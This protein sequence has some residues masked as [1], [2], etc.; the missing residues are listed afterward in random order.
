MIPQK[1]NFFNNILF[2][3]QNML[4]AVEIFAVKWYN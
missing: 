2:F 4:M 3:W 1:S